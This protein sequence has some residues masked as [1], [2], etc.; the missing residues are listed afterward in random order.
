MKLFEI[1]KALET[2]APPALQ[3]S[4]D[5]AKLITGNPEMEITK[6]LATL[7]CM[8]SIVDE[9]IAKG[10]NLIIAHHPIV[11]SGMKSLTGANYVEQTVIKAIKNDIAIYAMHT[12][13]DNLHY[14][15]N[16]KIGQKLGLTN[17]KTL[18]P[19][20]GLIKK[21]FTYAPI[22]A[23][24]QVRNALFSAGAGNI[25]NYDECSFNTEG[26][27]TFRGNDSSN[28]F[29][30]QKGERHTESEVKIE[31]IFEGFKQ[32]AIL[33]ALFASHPYEEVAY[34]IF[35]TENKHQ[36]IG[37]GMIGELTV[38]MSETEFLKQVAKTFNCSTIRHTSILNRPIKKVAFCGGAG[39]FLLK[40]ARSQK[41]DV[42]ITG[43]FKYHEFFDAENQILVMDIGHYESEQFTPELFLDFLQEK[44]PTFAVLLSEVNTNP[45]HYFIS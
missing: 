28:P 11:F 21:L 45:I 33:N 17:L 6:A 34:E 23:A 26:K 8:E 32:G 29:V 22:S 3:E 10:C 1:I 14:G 16:Q 30:G 36:Q 27:G 13:L 31:V 25:G 2:W 24:E 5:N 19:K 15:V 41:A 42:F 20:S 18:A 35:A 12:N 9:A 38:E 7:D 40:S 4:Y 44:F 37:S 39:Q 43:D